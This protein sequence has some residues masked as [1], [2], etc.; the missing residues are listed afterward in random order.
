SIDTLVAALDW[1]A[2]AHMRLVNLSLGT[3]HGSITRRAMAAR[4]PAGRPAGAGG[5]GPAHAMTIVDSI[6]Q[7]ARIRYAVRHRL[8]LDMSPRSLRSAMSC[9]ALLLTLAIVLSAAA[10]GPAAQRRE[11]PQPGE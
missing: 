7:I 3:A 10:R 1:A 2:R 6:R 9:V 11:A 5:F 8:H 4:M